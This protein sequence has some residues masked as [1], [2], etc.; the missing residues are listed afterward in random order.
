MEKV[1][2]EIDL[3]EYKLIAHTIRKHRETLFKMGINELLKKSL[4][5]DLC[6]IVSILEKAEV[7]SREE[8][9]NGTDTRF[10]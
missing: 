10:F 1:T 5:Q 2:L 3:H 6:K 9:H 7:Q 4:L 8:E